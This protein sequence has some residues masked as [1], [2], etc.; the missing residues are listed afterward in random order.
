MPAVNAAGKRGCDGM[1]FA[2]ATSSRREL[3]AGVR[4]KNV[5]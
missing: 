1:Q 5:K 2:Q 3:R 4:K